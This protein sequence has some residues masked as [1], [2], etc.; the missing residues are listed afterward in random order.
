MTE[1]SVPHHSK[2][3]SR[4]IWRGGQKIEIE[5]ENDRFT[6]MVSDPKLAE[7]LRQIPGIHEVQPVTAQIF[8][9]KTTAT[10]L[11]NVMER[12]RSDA[13]SAIAHHAY[14]PKDSE[15]TI[16]YLTDKIIVQFA[17]G[18]SSA[19]INAL[20]EKYHLNP[21]KQ[22]EGLPGSYLLQV[23][24]DSGANPVKIANQ[25]M[26]EA[27]VVSAEPNLVNRFQPGFFPNDTLFQQQW[28]LN[29][30]STADV[31]QEASINAA[32]AWEVTRG[33][34]SIVVAVM[35]DGFDIE[36]PDFQGENKIVSPK[37]YVNGDVN[38][39]PRN[40]DRSYHG[41]SCAGVAIA[42]CNGRGVVGVAPGCAFMPV[43]FPFSADDDLLIEIF[44]EIGKTS[45]VISCSW[46]PPPVYSPLSIPLAAVL[47][48]LAE[49]G[50][51]RG[52][53]CV[54]CFAASNFNAPINDRVNANGFVWLDPRSRQKTT[55]VGPILNGYAAHPSVIA[56][57]ASTSLNH[58]AAYSNWGS[59]VSVCAPSN[60][61]HPLNPEKII[62]GLRIWTTM[63]RGTGDGKFPDGYTGNFG[64]TS[65]ATPVVAGVAALVLSAN[66]EL[67]AAEVKE[68]LQ[69]TADKIVDTNLD[70]SGSIR[71]QYDENG[72]CEWF[73]YGK[74]NAAK[75]V[76]EAARRKNQ[77]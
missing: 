60:N 62:P 26:E 65:S 13:Y 63:D 12:L 54:I 21:M 55:T 43:R 20:F 14:R 72:H 16:Y 52:K 15:G 33:D 32:A 47:T 53:G 19:E 44:N 49:T 73:G 8:K 38:P 59:E 56:V 22:Y 5:K 61:V 7:V 77:R 64:G 28:H 40:S 51:P 41:T 46:G 42:E 4:Y 9:I 68:I 29:A 10:N 23:T 48:K 66:S 71:G 25:L 24:S 37:D 50:G 11:G 6:V 3:L 75:A 18:V 30:E 36:H 31:L 67:S 2:D 17:S 45:H 69:M 39:F 1:K 58:H 70:T 57:S 74:V 34:R 76:E 27:I 35:D